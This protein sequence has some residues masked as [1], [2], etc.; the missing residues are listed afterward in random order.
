MRLVFRNEARGMLHEV[1]VPDL[2]IKSSILEYGEEER[3]DFQAPAQ[4]TVLTYVCDMHPMMKGKL[5]V[6]NPDTGS[7]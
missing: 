7:L 4:D 2:G 3:L 6:G 5:V 1:T